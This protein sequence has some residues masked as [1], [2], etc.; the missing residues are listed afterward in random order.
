MK[1]ENR[2]CLTSFYSG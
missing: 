1:S 2:A